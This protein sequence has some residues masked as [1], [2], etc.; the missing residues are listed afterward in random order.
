MF[1]IV[2]G[3]KRVFFVLLTRTRR[4]KY[5]LGGE[6]IVLDKGFAGK[7]EDVSGDRNG[8]RGGG[9]EGKGIA[10]KKLESA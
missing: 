8:G 5:L 4:R 6:E 7:L 1:I 9:V 3:F 2:K 10:I